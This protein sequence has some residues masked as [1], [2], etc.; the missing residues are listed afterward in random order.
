MEM[1]EFLIGPAEF[2]FLPDVSVQEL[3]VF[4]DPL[5][6]VFPLSRLSGGVIVNMEVPVLCIILIEP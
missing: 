2:F 6:K 5:L 1:E 3:A 4:L